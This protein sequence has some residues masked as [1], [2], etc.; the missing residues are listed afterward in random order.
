MVKVGGASAAQG[1][2][3]TLRRDWGARRDIFFLSGS[4]D[5]A[6]TAALISLCDAF[7]SLHRAEGFGLPIAEAMAL[8]RPAVATGWSGNMDFTD[9]DNALC[10]NYQLRAVGEN[11]V[12]PYDSWQQWAEPDLD[13]A[14]DA[15]RAL[16]ESSALRARL[17]QAG[18]QRIRRDY[19]PRRCGQTIRSTLSDLGQL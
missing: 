17:G 4:F 10:V 5:S 14:A 6:R 13:E 1:E 12:P 16:S 11:A 18:Q 2:L 7:V 19:S 8:G 9:A 3:E 15:L